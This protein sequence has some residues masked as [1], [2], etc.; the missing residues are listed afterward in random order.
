LNVL[1][2]RSS[3]GAANS[4][5]VQV[6]GY[7]GIYYGYLS[8]VNNI[9]DSSPSSVIAQAV[10]IFSQFDV[11]VFADGLPDDSPDI[12]DTEMIVQ[13]LVKQEKEVY[14]YI[15]LGVST[16]NLSVAQMQSAVDKWLIIGVTG[17]FWDDVGYDYGTTRQRQVEMFNYTHMKVGIFHIA[18]ISQS[19]ANFSLDLC[20]KT[21]KNVFLL[22]SELDDFRQCL[23][24]R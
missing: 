10:A 6:P 17:I 23:G 16:T 12:N 3:I 22:F 15:D 7:L 21:I 18:L 4:L 14:G 20:Q 24:S 2:D 1:N 13:Q 8:Q 19:F 5:Q 9:T 11:L